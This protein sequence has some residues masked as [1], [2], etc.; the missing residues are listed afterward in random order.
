MEIKMKNS[1][2]ENVNIIK[3]YSLMG[4]IVIVF[5]YMVS[6]INLASQMI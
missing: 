2:S 5:A 3:F 6:V 1:K 4:A